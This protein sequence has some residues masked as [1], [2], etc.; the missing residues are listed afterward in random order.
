[1]YLN[2]V[3][4]LMLMTLKAYI[5]DMEFLLWLSRL[6]IRLVSMRVQVQSLG[7]LS[8]LRIWHCPELW[9]RSQTWLRSGGA[10]AVEKASSFTSDGTPSLDT[11]QL[12][13]F[14]IFCIKKRPRKIK[15]AG[16]SIMCYR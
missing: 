15:A 4:Y 1:M 12:L 13:A 5:Y 16:N 7:L 2:K 11:A 9:C 10:V 6:R 8:G 14:E 3:L